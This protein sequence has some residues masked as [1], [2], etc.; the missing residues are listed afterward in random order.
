MYSIKEIND[1]L[2]ENE[3]DDSRS[4]VWA[5]LLLSGALHMDEARCEL[6]LKLVTRRQRGR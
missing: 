6:F 4:F 5:W 1:R 3:S 2:V